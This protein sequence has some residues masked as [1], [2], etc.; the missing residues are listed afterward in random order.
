LEEAAEETAAS[1]PNCLRRTFEGQ[2][3][4][5]APEVLAPALVEFFKV[6]TTRPV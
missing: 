3:H 2:T 1:L 5:V 4:A 6:D